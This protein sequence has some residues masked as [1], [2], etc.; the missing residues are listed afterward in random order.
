MKGWPSQEKVTVADTWV[1]S[2]NTQLLRVL[3]V[4][5]TFGQVSY[6]FDTETICNQASKHDLDI[7]FE[8]LKFVKTIHLT[9][10]SIIFYVYEAEKENWLKGILQVRFFPS[11]DQSYILV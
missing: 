2:S 4:S 5:L 9:S 6:Y 1:K 11:V 3:L 8:S 10:L 7:F